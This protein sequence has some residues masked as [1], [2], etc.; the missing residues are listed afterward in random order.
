MSTASNYSD[1]ATEISIDCLKVSIN[2]TGYIDPNGHGY[3]AGLDCDV[4]NQASA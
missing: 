2:V 3:I 4:H 1:P